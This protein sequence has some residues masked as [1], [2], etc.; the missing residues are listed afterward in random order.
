ML[1]I[2]VRYTVPELL[3]FRSGTEICL[4]LLWGGRMVMPEHLVYNKVA[5]S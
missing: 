3:L 2:Y 4:T 1:N 5:K